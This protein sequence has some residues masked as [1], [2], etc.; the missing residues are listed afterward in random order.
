MKK[1]MILGFAALLASAAVNA[2]TDTTQKKDTLVKKDST[3]THTVATNNT[4]GTTA[5]VNALQKS[6]A[7]TTDLFK[8]EE[9]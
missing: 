9:N 2:Q 4:K 8:K 7:T 3:Q 6:K 1:T 5:Q